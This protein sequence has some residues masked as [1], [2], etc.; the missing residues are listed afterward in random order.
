MSQWH[1][2]EGTGHE[3]R[4]P[5]VR[6]SYSSIMRGAA[7]VLALCVLGL[8]VYFSLGDRATAGWRRS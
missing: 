1:R 5:R 2:S 7:L 6:T 4:L 8:P 3:R